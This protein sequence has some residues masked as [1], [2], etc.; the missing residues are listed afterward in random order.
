MKVFGSVGLLAVLG[1]M[2]TTYLFVKYK[3][4]L[5]LRSIFV[6][7]P[8]LIGIETLINTKGLL[9]CNNK[10]LAMRYLLILICEM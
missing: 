9:V 5:L 10:L 7:L 1:V 3:S 2:L 8:V 4:M 6:V